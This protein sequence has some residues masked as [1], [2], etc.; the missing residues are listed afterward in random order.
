MKCMY[1]YL[2]LIRYKN[3]LDLYT[4]IHAMSVILS[5]FN[6]DFELFSTFVLL[7]WNRQKLVKGLFKGCYLYNYN[8]LL[9]KLM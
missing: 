4:H 1:L 8:M 5:M 3:V 7:Y 6:N 9:L 2:S